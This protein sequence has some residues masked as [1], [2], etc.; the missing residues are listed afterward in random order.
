M[1]QIPPHTLC[2]LGF[3][4][5]LFCLYV[6]IYSLFV[7]LSQVLAAACKIFFRHASSLWQGGSGVVGLRPSC[8]VACGILVAQTGIESTS[9][10]LQ[11]GFF[12]PGPPGKSPCGCIY[13]VHFFHS[14]WHIFLISLLHLNDPYPTF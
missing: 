10:A 2:G 8:P 1:A 4:V 12:I 9:S 6:F 13:T 5:C 14:E 7:W 3:L 11:G